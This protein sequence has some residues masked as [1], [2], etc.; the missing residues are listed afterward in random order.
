MGYIKRTVEAGNKIF[1]SKFLAPMFGNHRSRSV[2]LKETSPSVKKCNDFH[3]AE[4]CEAKILVN[5]RPGDWH[6]SLTYA[7]VENLTEE[8]AKKDVRNFLDRL[9]RRCAKQNITLRYVKMT[10]RSLKGRLHHHLILPQEIPG[11]MILECW[12]HGIVKANALLGSDVRGLAEYFVDKTKKGQKNDDRPKN[13]ARYSFS[14][15]CI[16]PKITYENISA[17]KWRIEP[18]APKGFMLD[19]NSV[20]TGTSKMGYEYQRYT[21]VRIKSKEANRKCQ[22]KKC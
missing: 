17:S 5:F 20:V 4:K 12:E 7:D 2:R 18:K 8:Q 3:A 10:E 22:R 13:T 21:L 11:Q 6:I 15:N 9:K 19:K 16:E 1:V 14:R